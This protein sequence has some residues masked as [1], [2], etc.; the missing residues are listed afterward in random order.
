MRN[1]PPAQRC[2][3]EE[4]APKGTSAESGLFSKLFGR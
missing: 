3:C 1:V 2:T 4:N